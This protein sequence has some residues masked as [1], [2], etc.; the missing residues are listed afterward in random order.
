M[1]NIPNRIYLQTGLKDNAEMC[2]DFNELDG[3][4]WCADK[5]YSD[6]LQFVSVDF[7]LA[8]IE[9]LKKNTVYGEINYESLVIIEAFKNLIK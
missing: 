9:K 5:I 6:D 8:E 7:I 3:I 2:E 4:S 1:K